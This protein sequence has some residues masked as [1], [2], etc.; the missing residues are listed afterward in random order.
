MYGLIADEAHPLGSVVSAGGPGCWLLVDRSES[1]A[2]D[3]FEHGDRGGCRGHATGTAVV[4]SAGLMRE[5]VD[6]L[7][8]T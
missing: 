2:I 8:L 7:L 5:P 6:S 1:L 3:R 4:T